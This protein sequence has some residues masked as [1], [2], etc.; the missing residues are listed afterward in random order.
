M[1]LMSRFVNRIRLA[2]GCWLAMAC[3]SIL[4]GPVVAQPLEW[5]PRRSQP[6]RSLEQL[7]ADSL[8]PA[9]ENSVLVSSP[10]QASGTQMQ[11]ALLIRNPDTSDGTPEYAL[12]DQ[13]GQVQRYVEQSNGINLAAYVGE[14][15]AVR[16]D[17]GET[18]LASQ[19]LL[20][21]VSGGSYPV[22]QADY[23]QTAKTRQTTS[24]SA[25]TH[26][27]AQVAPVVIDQNG[28]VCTDCNNGA[29]VTPVMGNMI[30]A[31]D[32]CQTCGP[33]Y[34]WPTTSFGT[35]CCPGSRGRFYG[36]AEW[37]LWW[38]DGMYAPPLVTGS[39]TGTAQS[40][41]GV[42][43][44]SGTSVLFGAGDIV[45]GSRN[46]LRFMIGT[47]FNEYQDLGI[48]GDVFFFESDSAGFSA[49]GTNGSPILARPFFNIAPVDVNNNPL[50]AAEDAELVSFPGLVEGTVAVSARS[51]FNGAGI[52]L[53]GAICCKEEGGGCSSCVPCGAAIAPTGVSRI[54]ALVGYRFLSLDE[55]IFIRE[56][57]NS[58]DT[59][60]PGTFNIYDRFDTSNEFHGADL[61]FN[62]E[63]ESD[64]WSFSV[65]S[66]VAIGNTHQRV[67]IAGQTTIS[68]GTNSYTEQGGLLALNSNIGSYR[69][70]VFSMVPELG[71]TL[72]FKVTP[73]LRA[74]VGYT[75]LYW[76][77][78]ARPGEH[79]DLDVNPNLLPPVSDPVDGAARPAFSWDD[80]SLLAHGLNVGLDC[81][82]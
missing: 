56:N 79:I 61:G 50:V 72:G 1:E 9:T 53:R 44:E 42:L 47:W 31:Y 43:G 55:R 38:F 32:T 3:A 73:H 18:L 75:L 34:S 70:D 78:V 29:Y 23:Q 74:T 39:P 26:R 12:A 14:R 19:L 16:S 33:Y 63:W 51:E 48:E 36:S 15:V 13:F 40:E 71:A 17:T 45:D 10:N 11:Q 2:L 81:R 62:W 21:A 37:L 82:F 64:R 30:N 20:P 25:P 54:D 58:L 35:S 80:T 46:G 24:A 27:T 5:S 4:V 41:A 65:L 68:D 52:R 57:L 76:T 49:T 8:S 60:N 69:R 66:K 59:S 7:A 67:N 22:T 28:S 77:N 6:I